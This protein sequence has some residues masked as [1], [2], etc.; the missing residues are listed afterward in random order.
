MADDKDKAGTL[1]FGKY[2]TMEEA[3]K[4]FKELEAAYGKQGAEYGEA[5]KLVEQYKPWVEKAIPVVEWYGKHADKVAAWVNKGMPV[6]AA[7]PAKA[8]VAAADDAARRAAAGTAGYE[9]LTPQEKAQLVGDIRNGILNDTLKPWTES[10]TKQA[11]EFATGL[12]TQFQ[13]QHRSFTD[14]LWR[15]FERV[16]PKDKLDEVKAWHEASLR[17]ADP[18][19]IDPMKIGEEFVGLSGENASLKARLAELEKKQ[20]DIEKAGVPSLF[21][22]PSPDI[23][24]PADT[25]A[26]TTREER[27]KAVLTNVQAEHGPEGVKALFPPS[28]V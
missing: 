9:W 6:E 16:L 5:K 25:G 4:G 11:Q 13:N 24:A 22:G 21:G 17:F 27:L 3:E 12:Q 8:E 18:S 23:T 14:V 19:K 2:K 15:T 26:P 10:F 28:L 20:T 1:L 7:A